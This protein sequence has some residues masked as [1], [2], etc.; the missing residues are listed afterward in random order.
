MS[1]RCILL[2]NCTPELLHGEKCK[3]IISFINLVTSSTS[4]FAVV[5]L[6]EALRD[7]SEGRGFDS[8]WCHWTFSVT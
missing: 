6:V 4:E 5:Q 2:L 7:K 8:L 3:F 1:L